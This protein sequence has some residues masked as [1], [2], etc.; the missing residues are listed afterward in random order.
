MG[1]N[2]RLLAST[3]CI[4]EAATNRVS[5]R[6]PPPRWTVHAV[7]YML[8]FGLESLVPQLLSRDRTESAPDGQCRT[9]KER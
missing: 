8:A 7:P 6:L 4:A 9:V 2:I 3:N 1:L 5:R